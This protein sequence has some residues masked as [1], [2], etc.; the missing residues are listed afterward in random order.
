M[1]IIDHIYIPP[2]TAWLH[3]S[4]HGSAHLR[5][6]VVVLTPTILCRVPSADNGNTN[7]RLLTNVSPNQEKIN[8]AILF[9]ATVNI[10]VFQ[11]SALG[12][13]VGWDS[14]GI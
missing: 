8:H 2:Y 13:A 6:V 11:Y 12:A 1:H 5:E 7:K 10:R 9:A 14:S 4:R 3:V